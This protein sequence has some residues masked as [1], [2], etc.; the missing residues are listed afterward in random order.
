[1]DQVHFQFKSTKY[2][3]IKKYFVETSNK[4]GKNKLQINKNKTIK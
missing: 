2:D 1:M 3:T 4:S